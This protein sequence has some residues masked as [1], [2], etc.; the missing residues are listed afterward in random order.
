[1]QMKI[2]PLQSI[3][4]DQLKTP[5]H[6]S[7][8]IALLN[9]ETIKSYIDKDKCLKTQIENILSRYNKK[10][11]TY[12]GEYYSRKQV[13]CERKI[14]NYE[15]EIETPILEKV[16]K[17]SNGFIIGYID[18]WVTINLKINYNEEIQGKIEEFKTEKLINFGI[19]VKPSIKSVGEVMRQLQTYKQH[20]GTQI[21]LATS[22]KEY[23]D[24]FEGQ[25]FSFWEVE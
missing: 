9:K 11:T 4:D 6:D 13:P 16:L 17:T 23:K 10:D 25:G 1:M 24:I 22:S 2:K 5:K 7:I 18:L 20:L 3:E 21:I 14:I 8:C 19:E 12:I 15:Y